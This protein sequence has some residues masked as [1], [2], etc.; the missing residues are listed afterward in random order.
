MA[1][2]MDDCMTDE[3][4]RQALIQYKIDVGPI[5]NSTRP[6]YIAKLR[7]KQPPIQTHGVGVAKLPEC[8]H[9]EHEASENEKPV[10]VDR[11]H[12]G[13][14]INAIV[15]CFGPILKQLYKFIKN[16]NLIGI[17]SNFLHN[18]STCIYIYIYIYIYIKNI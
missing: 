11:K 15:D 9:D 13:S 4:L 12:F 3:E 14:L 1:S 16:P 18:I 5:N 17:G 6:L 2:H 8:E 10:P 7:E